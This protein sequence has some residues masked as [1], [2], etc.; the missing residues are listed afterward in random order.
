MISWHGTS[1]STGKT[2][3]YV[4]NLY[5]SPDIVRICIRKCGPVM[6]DKRIHTFSGVTFAQSAARKVIVKWNLG[7]STPVIFV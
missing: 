3:P 1:L 4:C 2:L 5:R 7:K 6:G